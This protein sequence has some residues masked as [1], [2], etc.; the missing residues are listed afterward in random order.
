MPV[1]LDVTDH[2]INLRP[3]EGAG[4]CPTWGLSADGTRI[5][6]V[7]ETLNGYAGQ[8]E[9]TNAA[10]QL[11]QYTCPEK[12]LRSAVIERLEEMAEK[13]GIAA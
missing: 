8:I 6:T 3:T 10:G 13:L 5:G 2:V 4:L 11:R 9:G 7:W 12:P 1:K